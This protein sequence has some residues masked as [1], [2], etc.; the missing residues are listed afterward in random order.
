MGFSFTTE[1]ADDFK[2]QITLIEETEPV[3]GG[4]SGIDNRALKELG[5]RSGYLL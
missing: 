3:V 2:S 4:I 1:N 5:N